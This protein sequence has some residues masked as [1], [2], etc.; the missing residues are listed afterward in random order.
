MSAITTAA[1]GAD[2]TLDELAV[3]EAF[4][5]LRLEGRTVHERLSDYI[6]G[7]GVLERCGDTLEIGVGDA[8]LWRTG[9]QP[10]LDAVLA[11]G[12]LVLTDQD[13]DLV[14]RCA[15]YPLLQREGVTTR[16][17]DARELP[18]ADRCFARVM[19]THVLH[20][21]GSPDG[22]RA[23]VGELARVLAVDGRAL[24]TTVDE[25]VH[26][27]EVYSLL[28]RAAAA[29]E[30]AGVPVTEPIPSSS[31][32][33]AP[34]CAGNAEDFL[35]ERFDVVERVDCDYAHIVEPWHAQ[36]DVPGEV[37]MVRY[38]RTL[39]FVKEALR[40][41]RMRPELLEEVRVSLADHLA[42]DG[43]FRMSRRDVIYDCRQPRDLG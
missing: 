13:A 15:S 20:W 5:A 41:G 31:P 8:H 28:S 25:R 11:R 6:V 30:A 2:G 43:S 19:T 32:R 26:M 39:P 27:G 14:Q 29:I 38:L 23:A 40:S 4:R 36:L 1:E 24:V 18:F 42:R 17:A 33:V 12:E 10:L 3:W 21:C 9:G 37:F 7:S 35:R 34:F 22:V 16:R